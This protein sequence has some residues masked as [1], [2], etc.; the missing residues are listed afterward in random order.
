MKIWEIKNNNKFE[1]TNTKAF[2]S[3]SHC[4]ILQL[5]D[6]EFVTSSVNDKCIKFWNLND[7]S[8]IA[9][10]NNIECNWGAR[11]LCELGDDILG[12]GG[13]NGNGIYLI[14]ISK[15]Y[16]EKIKLK[17]MK[18]FIRKELNL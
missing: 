17:I 11:T 10:L 12:V 7:Y 1:C 2:Q 3:G 6:K 9:T 16:S 14:K 5:N 15:K 18:K 4:N 8:N 13:N